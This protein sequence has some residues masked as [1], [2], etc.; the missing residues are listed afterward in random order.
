MRG[1]VKAWL[2]LGP[3][4][5][6]GSTFTVLPGMLALLFAARLTITFR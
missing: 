3:G 5:F 2:S 4:Q 1:R 6:K